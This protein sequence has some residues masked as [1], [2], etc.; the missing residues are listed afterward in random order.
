[1]RCQ[2]IN[3]AAPHAAAHM[4]RC[5]ELL[6]SAPAC[7]PAPVAPQS[8]DAPWIWH[9]PKLRHHLHQLPMP[10]SR[11]TDSSVYGE[12]QKR[13]RPACWRSWC[14]R[15]LLPRKPAWPS[16]A[17]PWRGRAST[18]RPPPS[19]GVCPKACTTSLWTVRCASG[20][21]SLAEH[22]YAH[23]LT[24]R[25]PSSS[26]AVNLWTV[27][28][29]LSFDSS[30]AHTST[31]RPPLP[32]SGV[33]ALVARCARADEAAAFLRCACVLGVI[34]VARCARI[35][36]AAAF[37]GVG[38]PGLRGVRAPMRLPPSSVWVHLGCDPY[39]EVCAH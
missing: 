9:L 15:R 18:T 2:W 22:S 1:M 13:A 27:K 38:A 11:T 31:T 20:E 12:V 14:T 5:C 4:V 3:P 36:K 32:S 17:A 23:N 34:H 30:L 24:T 8:A 7:S 29:E 10:A 33:R 26:G 39:S 28:C 37:L 6:G 21:Q 25:P 35:D 16:R 19:S